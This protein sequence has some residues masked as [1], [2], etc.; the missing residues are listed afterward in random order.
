MLDEMDKSACADDDLVLEKEPKDTSSSKYN[1]S[2][3][4]QGSLDNIAMKNEVDVENISNDQ[5]SVLTPE[6]N[7]STRYV[8]F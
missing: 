1:C 2:D 4:D 5:E 6:E 3:Q 8:F 7:G